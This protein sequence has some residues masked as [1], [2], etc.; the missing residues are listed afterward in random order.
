MDATDGASPPGDSAANKMIIIVSVL[1]PLVTLMCGLRLHTRMR[2]VN[3]VGLD[4]LVTF[5]AMVR[6]AFPGTE[7][8]R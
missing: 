2:V 5:L 6:S 3:A 4:D 1:L 7:T 8:L